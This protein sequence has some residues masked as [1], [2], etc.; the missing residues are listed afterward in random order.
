ML[1]DIIRNDPELQKLS[2]QE[3]ANVLNTKDKQNTDPT[4]KAVKAIFDRLVEA[5]ILQQDVADKIQEIATVSVAE[6]I[7]GEG[8]VIEVSEV[9]QACSL[10]EIERQLEADRLSKEQEIAKRRELRAWWDHLYREIGEQI[11]GATLATQKD[12]RDAIVS[13]PG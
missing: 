8:A 13:L 12:V 7:K 11:D 9:K 1:I 10:I 6:Q 5:K 3:I 2:A 4:F